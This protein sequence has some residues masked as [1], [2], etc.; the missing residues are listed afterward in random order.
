MTESR[1]NIEDK[2]IFL[3]DYISVR[4]PEFTLKDS[5]SQNHILKLKL[6]EHDYKRNFTV[7]AQ[8]NVLYDF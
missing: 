7:Y 6:L 5:I 8:S 2:I 1:E 4:N 3:E